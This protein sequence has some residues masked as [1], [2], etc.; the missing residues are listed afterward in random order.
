MSEE[1]SDNDSLIPD[2]ITLNLKILEGHLGESSLVS[3]EP[4]MWL[5]AETDGHYSLNLGMGDLKNWV[6]TRPTV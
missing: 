4:N 5:K 6:V 2:Y 3:D 1:P